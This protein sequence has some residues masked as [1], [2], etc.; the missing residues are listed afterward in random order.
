MRS[1]P[2]S[3]NSFFAKEFIR[4]WRRL[5]HESLRRVGLYDARWSLLPISG[6]GDLSSTDLR[7]KTFSGERLRIEETPHF[8]YVKNRHHTNGELSRWEEYVVLQFN[9]GADELRKKLSM[10]DRLI[11]DAEAGKASFVILVEREGDSYRIVDGLHRA[12]IQA[13]LYPETKVRCAFLRHSR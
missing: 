13:A 6:Q 10:F 11:D 4:T 9:Y 2:L 12:A 7:A 3:V 5:K 1:G 8:D